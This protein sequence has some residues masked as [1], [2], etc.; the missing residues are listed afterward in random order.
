MLPR[1]PKRTPHIRPIQI[2]PQVHQREE[3]TQNPRLQI[4]RQVQSARR[5]PR[6]TLAAFRNEFHDFALP[7]V[8]GVPQCRLPSH[9]GAASLDGQR[10][11]QNADLLLHHGWWCVVLASRYFAGCSHLGAI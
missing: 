4:V 5:H 9:L 7:I 10:E 2:F 1:P 11:M 3:S 8:W 6:Q